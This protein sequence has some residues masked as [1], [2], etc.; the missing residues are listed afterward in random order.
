MNSTRLHRA[1]RKLL[2]PLRRSLQGNPPSHTIDEFTGGCLILI[3]HPDDEVFCSG[4]ICELLSR[5]EQVHLVSFTRGEGGEQAE[6]SQE[7]K[8][9]NI[10]ENELQEAA[11]ILSI[12]SLTF[13]DYIDPKSENG[14]LK[15]PQHNST[16]LIVELETLL[17]KH[18]ANHL[19]THGSNG[20]Y[21]HPAHLCLH[22]HARK[23]S[24]RLP[25]LNLWTFNAW[26]KKHPLQGILNQDDPASLTLD[27]SKHQEQRLQSLTSHHSQK[28][29]F[30]RFS[31]GS[32][33]DFISLTSN[34]SFRK[35]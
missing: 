6:P 22:R 7:T 23:L 15:E 30:Q 13:L 9:G 2:R 28:N 5:G 20:E 1:T 8:L 35:W 27:T 32:L 25:Q 34:E 11:K 26:T 10:R 14:Q 31:Q 24:Q 17:T 3:A 29:V 21:W 12:S 16:K 18:S 33:A 19:L 4:L